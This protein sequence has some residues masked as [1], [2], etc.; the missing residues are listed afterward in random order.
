M[1]AAQSLA[2]RRA[3]VFSTAARDQGA[4]PLMQATPAGSPAAQGAGRALA[5]PPA[6][7][8]SL[9]AAAR[10]TPLPVRATGAAAAPAVGAAVGPAPKKVV[11]VVAVALIDAERRVL[12]AQRPEGRA[13]AG[14][15][16]FPGG[17]VHR[18]R[19]RGGGWGA[20]LP[21][22]IRH[23]DSLTR[24]LLPLWQAA[25]CPSPPD[26]R[27]SP[28][29]RPAAPHGRQVDP[30]EVP[31]AAL[32]RELQEELGIEVGRCGSG[33][34]QGRQ[35][36]GAGCPP[37]GAARRRPSPACAPCALQPR[38]LAPPNPQRLTRAT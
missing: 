31:E 6:A 32:V 3:G 10:P 17:K 16:E 38:P 8:P 34:R 29:D 18:A 14:L 25:A 30:G 21:R 12:L 7:G 4:R 15:W 19:G 27:P 26:P 20:W 1:R 5:A 22:S 13:M 23:P 28:P 33:A 11:L 37:P 24:L 36:S 2:L 35:R 9:P